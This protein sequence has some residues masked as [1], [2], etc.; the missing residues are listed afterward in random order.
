MKWSERRTK[1][2]LSQNDDDVSQSTVAAT[3]RHS[4]EPFLPEV[5]HPQAN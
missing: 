5:Q 1:E 4:P 3:D 2:D